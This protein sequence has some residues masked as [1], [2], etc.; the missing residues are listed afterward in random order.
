MS[1][2]TLLTGL[3]GTGLQPM[4]DRPLPKMPGRLYAYVWKVSGRQQVWLC[5]LTLLLFPLTLAPLELQ[6]RIVDG[7]VDGV[8][9]GDLLFLG[10][11]YFGVVLVQGCLK[12]IRNVHVDRVREGVTRLLRLRMAQS[13][14]FHVEAD[15]GTK[16]SIITAE[17]EKIGGFVSESIAFPFLQAGIVVSVAGYMLVVESLMAVVALGFFLPFLIAV[18][19]IQPVLD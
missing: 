18:F 3:Y 16:Q 9:M 8:R 7:A 12:Y 4:R 10:G 5:L 2:S 19:V 15:D 17:A 13:K 1:V 14:M 6:R 11:L